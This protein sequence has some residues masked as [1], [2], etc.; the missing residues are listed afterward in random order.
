[1]GEGSYEVAGFIVMCQNSNRL[2]TKKLQT[3]EAIL[4]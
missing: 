4:V 1:M 3:H 2:R